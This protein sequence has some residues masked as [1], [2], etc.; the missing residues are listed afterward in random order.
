M[1]INPNGIHSDVG[2]PCE[3]SFN[4][5]DIK[6]FGL[7]HFKLVARSGWT[8][9]TADSPADSFTPLARCVY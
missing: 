6:S 5:A 3:F 9:V 1:E 8:E 7:P 2:S 4:C